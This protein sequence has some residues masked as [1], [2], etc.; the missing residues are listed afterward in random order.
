MSKFV[1]L[2]L[3]LL[4][5]APVSA[6]TALE[7]LCAERDD[8]IAAGN[9]ELGREIE[10]RI[11]AELLGMQSAP[12]RE[13]PRVFVGRRGAP[14]HGFDPDVVISDVDVR[15][16]DTDYSMDG[17]MWV[18]FSTFWDDSAAYIFKST[19]HGATWEQFAYM[20]WVPKL[21]VYDVGIVV[22]E[23]DSGHVHLF[24]YHED[25]NGSCYDLRYDRSGTLLGQAPV[26]IRDDQVV[27]F[28]FCRDYSGSDY[29][30]YGFIDGGQDNWN[31]ITRSTD[32]GLSWA[33]TD[34]IQGW[35]ADPHVS[36]SAGTHI[37][38]AATKSLDGNEVIAKVNSWYGS[39]GLWN[40][41]AITRGTS[42]P[43]HGA[44][45]SD[46]TTPSESATVWLAWTEDSS[47]N[48]DD[49]IIYAWTTDAGNNWN[50]EG[51]LVGGEGR[52]GWADLHNYTSP[53]NAW[54]NVSYISEDSLLYRSHCHADD[55]TNW[56][57]G[58]RVNVNLV[59]TSSSAMPRLVYSPGCPGTGAGVVFPGRTLSELLWNAPWHT[60]IAE[61][62][63]IAR[64][65]RHG[66]TV[67]NRNRLPAELETRGLRLFDPSG[68]EVRNP[69]RAA[70]GVYVGV[71]AAETRTVR[72]VVTD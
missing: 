37:Y 8:A 14:A 46:F 45:A 2:S 71:S 15:A 36:A 13:P 33:I 25:Y 62:P 68:R 24:M 70:P 56:S 59:G 26:F 20:H 38:Y 42:S 72:L 39:P 58:T 34:S 27:G 9:R 6:T 16:L 40:Q 48:W 44:I 69:A 51:M 49:D 7:K 19:D 30:L 50:F 32:Y 23:G 1:L 31:F 55:P 41:W 17:T 4:M 53:G 35:W 61:N 65:P 43:W 60:G 64:E 5:A 66:P 12:D 10:H 11:Q 18:A 54:M 63:P 52:Q 22:G 28:N 3:V 47:G 29:W 21:P 57:A 67:I